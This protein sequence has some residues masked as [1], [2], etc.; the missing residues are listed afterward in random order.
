MRNRSPAKSGEVARTEHPGETVRLPPCPP[1]RA[2]AHPV[3]LCASGGVPERRW[4]GAVTGREWGVLSQGCPE[5]GVRAG[6]GAGGPHGASCGDL[7]DPSVPSP[8]GGAVGD[9]G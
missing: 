7:S 1:R 5:P 6:W 3:S 4:A 8:A 2:A 9:L